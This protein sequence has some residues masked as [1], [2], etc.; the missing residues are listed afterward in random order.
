MWWIGWIL[1]TMNEKTMDDLNN[2]HAFVCG[3]KQIREDKPNNLAT[4]KHLA[5]T[6]HLVRASNI[7]NSGPV[8]I[9]FQI[10]N[11]NSCILPFLGHIQ[12]IQ[13]VS[14]KAR[15][16]HERVL[17]QYLHCCVGLKWTE[18]DSSHCLD[19]NYWLWVIDKE[20]IFCSSEG[21]KHQI[22]MNS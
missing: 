1:I 10:Q 14:I 8:G 21:S 20:A 16:T 22:Q 18:S 9:N 4:P 3:V 13:P 17:S 19:K 2:L 5:W 7:P 15:K 6:V 11:K 12:C